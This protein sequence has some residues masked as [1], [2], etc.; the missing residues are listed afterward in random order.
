MYNQR[1]PIT[2]ASGSVEQVMLKIQNF[3]DSF[4][5]LKLYAQVPATIECVR[6]VGKAVSYLPYQGGC[7]HCRS[8]NRSTA[9]VKASVL[10]ALNVPF[11]IFQ[12]HIKNNQSIIIPSGHINLDF[13]FIAGNRHLGFS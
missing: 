12:L 8:F 3:K 4:P 9:A 6:I 11:R 7:T 1:Y 5:E 10:P 13:S 2:S